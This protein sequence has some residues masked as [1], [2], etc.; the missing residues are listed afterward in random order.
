MN[1]YMKRLKTK[2]VALFI[3]ALFVAVAGFMA[4]NRSVTA[5][6]Q[7]DITL[8]LSETDNK[9]GVTYAIAVD[10]LEKELLARVEY[11]LSSMEG[12]GRYQAFN[13]RELGK[14]LQNVDTLDSIPLKVTFSSPLSQD[15]FT[16]FVKQYEIDVDSYYIYML[17]ADG[18][19]VTIQGSPSEEDL[20]PS[21]FFNAATNS[22]SQE[23]SPGVEFL[24]WVEMDGIV[25]ANHVSQLTSDE[26][27]FLTDVMQLFLESKLTDEALAGVGI[28]KGIRQELVQFGFANIDRSGLVA[29]GLYHL[30]LADLDTQK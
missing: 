4:S 20:V 16:A 2:W 15:E 25:Q 13:N 28:D 27:V 5:Q 6:P 30:G 29:W 1:Y 26:R 12:I 7:E 3:L 24:G 11:D 23:Y 14:I 8:V 10:N 19:I 18:K 22:V 21:M 17:E 9:S